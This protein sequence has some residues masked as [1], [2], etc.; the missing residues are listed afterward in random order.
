MLRE[1]GYDVVGEAGDGGTA[2]E[3]ARKLRP[4]L[5]VMVSQEQ[6]WSTPDWRI[7]VP[8]FVVTLIAATVAIARREKSSAYWLATRRRLPLGRSA[9]SLVPH[10]RRRADD[11]LAA[12]RRQ[13]A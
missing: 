7:G 11:R 2:V 4:D 3:M 8:G 13:M 6:I 12:A 5:V 1:E 9:R 10:Q